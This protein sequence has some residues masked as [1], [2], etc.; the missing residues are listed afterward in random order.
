MTT[1]I[2]YAYRAN[3]RP[4]DWRRASLTFAGKF[5][6]AYFIVIPLVLFVVYS[7]CAVAE[8]YK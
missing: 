4:F 1:H 3:R 6:T 8:F 7:S 2:D 5:W